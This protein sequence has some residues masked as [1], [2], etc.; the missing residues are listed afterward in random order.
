MLDEL[1][2]HLRQGLRLPLPPGLPE[3]WTTLLGCFGVSAAFDP[4]YD[5]TLVRELLRAAGRPVQVDEHG[6]LLWVTPIA[7]GPT[8]VERLLSVL[9]SPAGTTAVDLLGHRGDRAAITPLSKRIDRA[10]RPHRGALWVALARLGTTGSG[11][12]DW[13]ADHAIDQLLARLLLAERGLGAEVDELPAYFP[14]P[15]QQWL[16]GE[17]MAD[18]LL[19][20]AGR[21]DRLREPIARLML[22]RPDGVFAR[23]VP[24]LAAFSLEDPVW[25]PALPTSDPALLDALVD[26]L[27]HDEWQVRAGAAVLVAQLGTLP[28]GAEELLRRALDDDDLDV[29]R[30]AALALHLADPTVPLDVPTS[31]F[32]YPERARLRGLT[33]PPVTGEAWAL[34]T[35]HTDDDSGQRVLLSLAL[36]D[37]EQYAP[38]LEA[39]CL[40]RGR[41]Q[42]VSLRR[43]AAAALLQA[44]K[45]PSSLPEVQRILLRPPDHPATPALGA[46]VHTLA[47]L[48]AR[49]ADWEVRLGAL[50]LLARSGT[51]LGVHASLLKIVA[52]SDSDPSVREEAR[53]L[54]PPAYGTPSLGEQIADCLVQRPDGGSDRGQALGLLYE[55][56]PATAV[57]LAEGLLDSEHRELALAAAR[58]VAGSVTLSTCAERV[59][60]P[61]VDLRSENWVR[62]EAAA[63]FLGCLPRTAV[64]QHLVDEI[65]EL[66]DQVSSHDPD[67]DVRAMAGWAYRTLRSPG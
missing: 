53:A 25:W 27:Q 32:H 30:E 16:D 21:D 8:A 4:R 29:R 14:M 17:P 57:A 38:L 43:A 62:R 1:L 52:T 46:D 6:L 26:C 33:G 31:R 58:I 61:L 56:S 28:D 60:G 24:T 10:G 49:D 5:T 42:P 51:P 35:R 18:E 22:R 67:E 13:T 63:A 3:T 64:I 41:D 48:V 23:H 59:R 45:V 50:R 47:A 39:F 54:L 12:H 66:L 55:R 44:L 2:L 9:D 37:P 36:E 7:S 40:D 34:L 15:L 20:L 11:L 19:T 65:A